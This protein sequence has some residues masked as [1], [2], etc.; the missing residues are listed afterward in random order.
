MAKKTKVYPDKNLI[1]GALRRLFARSPIVQ[2][3]KLSALHPT[4]RGVRGGK[5]YRCKK[6]RGLY[7]SNKVQVDHISEIVD[8]I[9]VKHMSYNM[10]VE[11]I[12]CKKSNLQVL[13]LTCHAEKTNKYKKIR[14]SY[15]DKEKHIVYETINKINGKKYIGVH[16]CFDLDDG[17]LGSGTLFKKAL[18]KYGKDNFERSVLFASFNKD[19]AYNK[20]RDLI[21][22]DKVEGDEYYNL[23]TGGEGGR[24]SKESIEKMRQSMIG[25]Y[26]GEKNPNYGKKHDAETRKRIGDREYKYGSEHVAAR[27]V[28]CIETGKIYGSIKETGLSHIWRAIKDGTMAGGYHWKYLDEDLKVELKQTKKAFRKVRNINTGEEFNSLVEAGKK[29][30]VK[31]SSIGEVC[32]CKRKTA[33]KCKWEFI[34]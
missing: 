5:Q 18:K 8:I 28:Q 4:K 3:V 17:Y 14:E 33:A 26:T 12:F 32:R 23:K 10:L 1:K 29:Y 7:G 19:E 34:D 9:P 15:K 13:C 16:S 27:K 22:Q 21:T 24:M 30:N 2:E 31:S 6:C 20:E 25:K 11:R